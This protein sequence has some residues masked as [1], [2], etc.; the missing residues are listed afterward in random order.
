MPDQPSAEAP[1]PAETPKPQASQARQRPAQA[2]KSR[3]VKALDPLKV[4]RSSGTDHMIITVSMLVVGASVVLGGQQGLLK[5]VT[6]WI[7]EKTGQTPPSS[8]SVDVASTLK[9]VA[10]YFG[11]WLVL[12]LLADVGLGQVAAA[13]AS[14]MAVTT[15][16]YEVTEGKLITNI[17]SMTGSGGSG[18]TPGAANPSAPSNQGTGGK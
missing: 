12:A 10:A 7:Q 5:Q 8:A 9:W 15:F 18:P 6:G 13:L 1:K 14:A 11:A 16:G 2:A 4:K 3:P 17:Q